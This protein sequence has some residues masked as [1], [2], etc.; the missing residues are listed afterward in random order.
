MKLRRLALA[1]IVVASLGTLAVAPSSAQTTVVKYT[2][3]T[4]AASAFY[5]PLKVTRIDLTS[6]AVDNGRSYTP[7]EMTITMGTKKLGPYNVGIHI[8]GG[9]GSTRGIE[10]KAGFKVK[11]DYI[12]PNATAAEKLKE[13]SQTIMGLQKLTLNNMVQDPSMLH[14]AVAYR[15]FRAMGVPAPRVGYATV[16]LN[17]NNYGLHATIETMDTVSMKRWFQGTK[18][19]FEGSYFPDVTSNICVS[20]LSDPNNCDHGMSVDTGSK[21]KTDD[22][23]RLIRINQLDGAAWYQQMSAWTD[24]KEMTAFWAA[25]LYIGHWDGYVHNRNNYYLHSDSNGKFTMMPW[26]TDQTF[27]WEDDPMTE[28]GAGLMFYKCMQSVPCRSMYS[29]AVLDAWTKCQTLALPAMVDAVATAIEPAMQTDPRR[30][31][32]PDSVHAVQAQTKQFL[33]NRVNYGMQLAR[34][35]ALV[36]PTI[37]ASVA[38]GVITVTWSGAKVYGITQQKFTLQKSTDN[39]TW[40]TVTSGMALSAKISS[41]AKGTTVYF[42][43]YLTTSQG[44]TPYSTV[45]SVKVL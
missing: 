35:Y 20:K 7:A 3:G 1:T 42:R 43:T 8:K 17:G 6:A 45:V 26:G 10:G 5:D 12:N 22:L 31:Y 13:K 33:A 34:S 40:T 28:S 44:D 15:L 19:I 39:Q 25:E 29:S 11:I 38:K 37:K 21:T 32:G 30:E 24:M 18:H 16:Y 27:G 4:D 41:V 36:S 9:W 14:E 2:E 23:D